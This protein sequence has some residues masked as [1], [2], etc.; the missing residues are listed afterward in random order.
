L[1]DVLGVAAVVRLGAVEFVSAW[2]QPAIATVADV[3][4]RAAK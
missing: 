3:R 1:G 4:R 2:P